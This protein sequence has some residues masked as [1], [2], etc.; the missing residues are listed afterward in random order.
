MY[1]YIYVYVYIYILC[2]WCYIYISHLSNSA[3]SEMRA[4]S[5]F[6]I[7][8]EIAPK[9]TLQYTVRRVCVCGVILG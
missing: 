4:S 3:C 7:Q 2:R 6:K 5:A 9:Q 1:I 8:P